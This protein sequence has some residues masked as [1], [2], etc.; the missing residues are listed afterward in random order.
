MI[1]KEIVWWILAI[2]GSAALANGIAL[3]G[4]IITRIQ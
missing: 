1:M 2:M 4:T 3:Y